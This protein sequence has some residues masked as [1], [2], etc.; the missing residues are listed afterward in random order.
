MHIT[1]TLIE[2]DEGGEERILSTVNFKAFL[3][4]SFPKLITEHDNQIVV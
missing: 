4:F 2:Q 3:F 1:R